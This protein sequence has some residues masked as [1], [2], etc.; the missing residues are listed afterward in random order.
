M[1][2]D[3]A[4]KDLEQEM[5]APC[6][7]KP[8]FEAIEAAARLA[9]AHDFILALPQG[10]DTV[11][12]ERGV[13][14]SGGQRQRIAIARAAIRQAPILIL[15]EPAT[16]LDEENERA[17]LEAL[18]RL[19]LH[20][21]TFFITHDLK[22]AARAERILYLEQGQVLEHGTHAELLLAQGR[23]ATLYNL[24][25]GNDNHEHRRDSMYPCA[26]PKMATFEN[27]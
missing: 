22:L 6:S 9:N 11:L 24:Q 7:T 3:N 5:P 12:G 20:R 23:Y 15:D 25:A 26:C 27:E 13:T 1:R 21:T 8:P 14:I 17:V 19:A 10:Y 4:V 2:A 16:G 18:E